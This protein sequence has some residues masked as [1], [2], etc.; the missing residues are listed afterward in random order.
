MLGCIVVNKD[1][2]IL[3]TTCEVCTFGHD[4][5][6]HA[7]QL[8]TYVYVQPEV[9]ELHSHLIPQLAILARNMVRDLD[10]QVHIWASCYALQAAE[11]LTRVLLFMACPESC[12]CVLGPECFSESIRKIRSDCIASAIAILRTC[13]HGIYLIRQHYQTVPATTGTRYVS[14][15]TAW[16]LMQN[17]LEFLRIRSM[18]QEIMVAPRELHFFTRYFVIVGAPA[19]K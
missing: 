9:A 8:S 11:Q 1:N 10:P 18:K 5:E 3:K 15:S 2:V 14:C 12:T 13:L 4:L 16:L 17:E 19:D 7:G 6:L